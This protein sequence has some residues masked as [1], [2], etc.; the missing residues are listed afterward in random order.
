MAELLSKDLEAMV[1]TLG[2]KHPS[3]L[4]ESGLEALQ[5]GLAKSAKQLLDTRQAIWDE[6]RQ[7]KK[8]I[9]TDRFNTLSE[10]LT[11]LTPDTEALTKAAEQCY[12]ALPT[13]HRVKEDPKN[14]IRHDLLMFIRKAKTFGPHMGKIEYRETSEEMTKIVDL[15]LSKSTELPDGR[16]YN[17]L[18]EK[19]KVNLLTHLLQSGKAKIAKHSANFLGLKYFFLVIT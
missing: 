1:T 5:V 7:H 9:P 10:Q 15:V 3:I 18:S 14:D 13:K 6:F 16:S 8:G 11:A 19:D 2:K 17:D 12:R 4:R